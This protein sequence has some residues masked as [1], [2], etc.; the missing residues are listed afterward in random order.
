M[1]RNRSLE[2]GELTDTAYYILLCFVQ[3]NHGYVVMQAVEEMTNGQ[4]S[5]GPASL[6]S[7]I[8]KLQS[9]DLIEITELG[10]K[11]KKTY[12][13][14]GKGIELLKQEVERRRDMVR[15]AEEILK[16]AGEL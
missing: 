15:H 8:Q 1:A 9:A 14:T 4:F 13:A 6:Y 11:K 2:M 7:T 16:S 10:D 3:E 5:I 12:R